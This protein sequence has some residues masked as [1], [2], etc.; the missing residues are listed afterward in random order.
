MNASEGTL[1]RLLT[2]GPVLKQR[3]QRPEVHERKDRG[4]WYWFFRYYDDVIQPDGLVKTFRRF[5]NIGPSRDK[6]NPMGLTQARAARDRFFADRLANP[7]AAP[8][9]SAPEPPAGRPEAAV[10]AREER[11]RPPDPADIKIDLLAELWRKD[12]V[13]NPKVKLAK[14]TR[15]KYKDRL[16]NHILPRW[17][18]KRLADLN[19]TK[20]VLDWLQ[21]SCTSWHM[22]IDLRNIMS[23]MITRAQEWGIIP[24]SFANPMQ[25]VKV[26]RKWS[27]RPDRIY[28][29]EETARIFER[30]PDPHLLIC[31][32]CLYTGTRISE[33]VGLQLKHVDLEAGTIRIA[34]RHCRGDV[35]SPKTKNSVRTLGTGRP[36]GSV[37]GVARHEGDRQAERLDLRAGRQT[38]RPAQR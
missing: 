11:E 25:W 24:R 17:R 18:G 14:P 1:L 38:R 16:A 12:Y 30:L 2:G 22:M 23:G 5:H 29:P 32:T 4:E 3:V 33:A 13:D 20:A 37:Q 31:E 28:T 36:R 7:G 26:G 10:Q 6:K 35:D 19:D 34:Q 27:V 15:D 8:P 21:D 9:P